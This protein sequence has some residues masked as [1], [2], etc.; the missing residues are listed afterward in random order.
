MKKRALR[1]CSELRTLRDSLMGERKLLL[2]DVEV[3][4]PNSK[5]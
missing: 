4:L 5:I 2:I 1:E 3:G